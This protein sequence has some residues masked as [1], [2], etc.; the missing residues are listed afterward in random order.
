M[1]WIFNGVIF[2]LDRMKNILK[3]V[4]QISQIM[5]YYKL[6]LNKV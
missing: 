2:T 1:V 3:K 6:A 5:Q 4:L